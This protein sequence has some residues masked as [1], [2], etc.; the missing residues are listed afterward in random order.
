MTEL[1]E[2]LSAITLRRKAGGG[3][4]FASLKA[5]D[6]WLK[7]LPVDSDYD[8]HHALVQG[9]ERFNAELEAA[10]LNRMKSLVRLEE[11]GL[12][13]QRRIVEQYVRNQGT[14]RLARQAL[15]R[16][17]WAFWSLLSEAW[18]K[19]LKE[20]Y[21]GPASA[22]LRPYAAEIATRA[23]R[24][25]GLAMRWDYHQARNP[26]A[27]AWRRMHKVYRLVE[28]D[29]FANQEVVIDARPTHC[30]REYTLVVLMGLVHPLGFRAQD[31]ETIA[32]FL[33]AMAPCRCLRSGC[34]PM[35]I[36]TGLI[37]P[38]VK[39]PVC[40]RTSGNTASVCVTLPCNRWS[41]IYRRLIRLRT[42][43][44]STDCR[45]RWRA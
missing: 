18:L 23:L 36:R 17:T 19:L 40:W 10:S 9:L 14:F 20:A 33:R 8:T 5:T 3:A 21:R 30:A 28:R 35:N 11:A 41:S 29:G 27:S 24:Y 2:M 4:P 26:G 39:A 43:R 13:L 31:I 12:P 15:W 34:I 6:R 1:F 45:A 44:R 16:E 42:A 25:T 22:D 37:F 32:R 7:R 38:I